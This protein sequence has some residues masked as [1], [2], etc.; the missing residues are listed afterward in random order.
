MNLE[1]E[2]RAACLADSTFTGALAGGLFWIRLPQNPTYPCGI[3]QRVST[4]PIYAQNVPGG[5]QAHVG[6]A[7]YTFKFWSVN[8]DAATELQTIV[9]ALLDVLSK[10]NAFAVPNSPPVTNQAPS[11]VLNERDGIESQIQPQAF[12][13]EVDVAVW[14]QDQ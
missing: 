13:R 10:L 7:R 2:I 5:T 3:F 14:Y 9:Q 11:F 1:T 12:W 8:G 6:K 4:V